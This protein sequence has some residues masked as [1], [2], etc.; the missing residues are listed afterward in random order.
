[1]LV[2]TI[3]AR[4]KE[5]MKAKNVVEREILRVL[6][7]EI[8]T[9]EARNAKAMSDEEALGV[10]KKLAKSNRETLE[11]STD[12][13]QKEILTA[14][15]AILESL[16]PKTMSVDEI[17]GALDAVADE[18]TSAGND[19]QATGVAMKHLKSTGAPVDGKRVAEAVKLL[20]SR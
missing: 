7:G 6:L 10:V 20:R 2:D 9:V 8:Q 13:A 16:L 4:V 11:L 18:V 12:A 15:I 3:K 1:M 17:V 14:E 5:A 19:G